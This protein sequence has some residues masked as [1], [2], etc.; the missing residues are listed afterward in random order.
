MKIEGFYFN[1]MFHAISGM[2][3]VE[4]Y[5]NGYKCTILVDNPYLAGKIRK[6]IEE[7]ISLDVIN[8]FSDFVAYFG[9]AY[10]YGKRNGNEKG[11]YVNTAVE[12][13]YE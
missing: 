7:A 2:A 8:N 4:G 5:V 12:R 11:W 6:E 9:L 1:G 3:V 13:K 10:K